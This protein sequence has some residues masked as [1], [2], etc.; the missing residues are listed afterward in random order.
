MND[1]S[2]D[3]TCVVDN[4]S[5]RY[6]V[7]TAAELLGLDAEALVATLTTKT[8]DIERG[9]CNIHATFQSYMPAVK[10]IHKKVDVRSE[11]D[12]SL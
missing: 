11:V 4:E 8:I 5:V 1:E 7:A 12:K 2:E 3:G 6:S 10:Y 9:S